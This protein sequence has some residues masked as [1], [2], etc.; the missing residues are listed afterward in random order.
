[1][2][3]TQEWERHDVYITALVFRGGS[4]VEKITPARAV[5]EVHVPIDRHDR[6]IAVTVS[7]PKLAKPEQVLPVSVKAPRLAG[8]EGVGDGIGG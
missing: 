7:A 6:R 2:T 8:Q 5:G 3:V 1:M 4:A